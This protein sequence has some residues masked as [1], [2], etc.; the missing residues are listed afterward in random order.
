MLL[1]IISTTDDQNIGLIID[2]TE[3][4]VLSNGFTFSPDRTIQTAP[5]I[6]RLFN[7]NYVIDAKEV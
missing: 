4:I 5:T 1:E 2:T 7:S 3:H 6:W